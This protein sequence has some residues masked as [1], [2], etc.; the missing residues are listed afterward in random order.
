MSDS[1]F[2]YELSGTPSSVDKTSGK[3]YLISNK[4]SLIGSPSVVVIAIGLKELKSFNIGLC[5]PV[6]SGLP[7]RSL[8][9]TSYLLANADLKIASLRITVSRR[10]CASL[11]VPSINSP[12]SAERPE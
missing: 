12:K 4:A 7:E 11:R 2:S 6:L 5:A 9:S 3:L 8:L 10:V 1:D